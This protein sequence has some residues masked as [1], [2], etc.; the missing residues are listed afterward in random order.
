M[1]KLKIGNVG[2]RL[3]DVPGLWRIDT[4]YGIHEENP[5][6]TIFD[7]NDKEANFPVEIFANEF[8]PLLDSFPD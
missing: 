1:T 6:I 4:I 2:A 5:E 3:D 7:I 8:W